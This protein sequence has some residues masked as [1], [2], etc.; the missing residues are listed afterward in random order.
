MG[1]YSQFAID[2]L[3][4]IFYAAQREADNADHRRRQ[5]IYRLE[6]VPITQE[7]MARGF[8]V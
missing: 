5:N 8:N 4:N 6:I 1:F 3:R 2:E 7:L